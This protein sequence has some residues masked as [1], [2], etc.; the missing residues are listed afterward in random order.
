MDHHPDNIDITGCINK[1]HLA[2]HKSLAGKMKQDLDIN[3][4]FLRCMNISNVD[5]M[6]FGTNMCKKKNLKYSARFLV[7][8]YCFR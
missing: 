3:G 1:T 7:K 8:E 2:L 6:S 4:I 5:L